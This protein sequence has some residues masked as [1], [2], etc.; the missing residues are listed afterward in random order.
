MQEWLADKPGLLFVLATLLPILSF[1]LLLLAAAV[2][3]GLR[4]YAKD[5]PTANSLFQLL[6]GEVTGRGPAY[7]ALAGIALAFLCSFVRSSSCSWPMSMN[8]SIWILPRI[9]GGHEHDEHA[10]HDDHDH[11]KHDDKKPAEKK[12]PSGPEKEPEAKDKGDKKSDKDHDHA[13]DAKGKKD[14]GKHAA[15]DEKKEMT[16]IQRLGPDQ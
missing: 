6:G 13:K 15:K 16:P 14:D 11:A 12:L 7:V 10:K 1:G 8:S 9:H 2:R 3:W 5:N 4:P